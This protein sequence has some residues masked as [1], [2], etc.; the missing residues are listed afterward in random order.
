M[1]VPGVVFP[2]VTCSGAMKLG[3]PS[4]DPVVVMLD[5]ARCATPKS[6]IFARPSSVTRMLAG[7]MSRWMMPRLWANVSP[8]ST[9]IMMS[10]FACSES[11]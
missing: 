4:K 10:S 5:D 3:V 6:M 9:S 1:S 8:V 7:L 2:S 11:G